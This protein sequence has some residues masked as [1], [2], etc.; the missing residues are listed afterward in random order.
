MDRDRLFAQL[1]TAEGDVLRVYDDAT[2]KPIVPGSTVIGHPTIGRGR[3]LDTHGISEAESAMLCGNDITDRQQA[4]PTVIDFWP[5]LSEVRQNA[6]AELSFEAGING[7]L[8]FHQALAAGRIGDWKT[9]SAQVMASTLPPARARRL[10]N[11]ILTNA[12][13]TA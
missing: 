12:W 5:Q 10:A 7:L 11:M 8:G 1:T 3:A 2:G 6:F 9:C 13:P 4:L